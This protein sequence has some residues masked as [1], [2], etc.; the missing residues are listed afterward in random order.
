MNKQK[1][2]LLWRVLHVSSP[3]GWVLLRTPHLNG[4][5]S[6]STGNVGGC[7]SWW[8]KWPNQ[9]CRIYQNVTKMQADLR[10]QVLHGAS[11]NQGFFQEEWSRL[12]NLGFSALLRN[13]RETTDIWCRRYT[14]QARN[15]VPCHNIQSLVTLMRRSFFTNLGWDIGS[16]QYVI[17]LDYFVFHIYW[18]TLRAVAQRNTV[19]AA[20]S[21]EL[22]PPNVVI[23][24]L[25]V[26]NS[27]NW[28]KI[29]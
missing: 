14:V 4:I 13:Y 10:L 29:I 26:V 12:C 28:F 16:N 25:S 7:F 2:Q 17:F 6:T 15:R 3:R 18:R 23:S 24:D 5:S 9:W 8:W 22:Q 11:R 1:E 27:Q 20:F 19:A 21:R